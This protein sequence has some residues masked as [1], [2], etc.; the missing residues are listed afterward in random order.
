MVN[1]TLKQC[2]IFSAFIGKL[3]KILERAKLFNKFV[4][5]FKSRVH[6]PFL[7]SKFVTE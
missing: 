1:E 4:H 5:Q 7:G 2:T 3:D 6:L